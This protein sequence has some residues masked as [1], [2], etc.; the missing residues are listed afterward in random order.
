M[1]NEKLLQQ[2]AK[3]VVAGNVEVPVAAPCAVG[4]GVPTW[5]D[6]ESE[7]NHGMTLNGDGN[8]PES[9]NLGNNGPE[10]RKMSKMT[11]NREKYQK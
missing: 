5:N 7:K 2:E 11:L 10:S 1:N 3:A 8:D 9:R 4:S 6:P